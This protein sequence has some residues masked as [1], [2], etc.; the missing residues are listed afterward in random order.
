MAW[1]LDKFFDNYNEFCETLKKESLEFSQ[2]FKG[3]M[4]EI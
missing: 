4:N 3:R 1:K 2:N